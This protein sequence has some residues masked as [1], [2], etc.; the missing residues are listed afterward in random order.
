M[1]ASQTQHSTQGQGASFNSTYQSGLKITQSSQLAGGPANETFSNVPE[2]PGI[3]PRVIPAEDQP[4]KQG[5]YQLLSLEEPGPDTNHE[6]TRDSFYD[7]LSGIEDMI[8]YNVIEKTKP[9]DKYEKF[10]KFHEADDPLE[11]FCK[12]KGINYTKC[13]PREYYKGESSQTEN[14]SPF[15][16]ITDRSGLGNSRKGFRE[17]AQFRTE[18][19]ERKAAKDLYEYKEGESIWKKKE[20]E[21]FIY[22]QLKK[23]GYACNPQEFVENNI[24]VSCNKTRSRRTFMQLRPYRFY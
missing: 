21:G 20:I 9:K 8:E 17:D 18:A 12:A 14:F 24:F 7:D 13:T 4:K 23:P 1:I 22:M 5:N 16:Y 2:R 15:L 3:H 11:A 6:T 19:D 10:K